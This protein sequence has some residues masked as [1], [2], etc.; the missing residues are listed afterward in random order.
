MT[1]QNLSRHSDRM[2]V[3]KHRLKHTKILFLLWGL[4]NTGT[5]CSR[6][7]MNYP[8]LEIFE[9][10]WTWS[11][12]TCSSWPCSNRRIEQGDFQRTHPISIILWRSHG[13]LAGSQFQD[14][15]IFLSTW[16]CLILAEHTLCLGF[17]SVR[18]GVRPTQSHNLSFL[19]QF[20][21]E[22]L[23]SE[24]ENWVHISWV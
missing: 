6:E 10:H 19:F 3:N 8:S 24:A 14:C 4:T 5:G 21:S 9:T 2:R 16:A 18:S 15:C 20:L 23:A 11:W 13:F 1:R 7:V 12:V 22:L 17:P